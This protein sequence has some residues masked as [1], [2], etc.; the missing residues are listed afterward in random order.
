MTSF[1]M[2]VS[3]AMKRMF[4]R[5]IDVRKNWNAVVFT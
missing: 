2:Y 5:M 1:I 4:S 3:M